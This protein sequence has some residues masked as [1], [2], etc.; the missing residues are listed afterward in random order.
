[1]K[2]FNP[3]TPQITYKTLTMRNILLFAALLIATA[4]TAQTKFMQ[5]LKMVSGDSMALNMTE[6]RYAVRLTDG[7]SKLFYG[8]PTFPYE[9]QSTFASI[10]AASCGNLVQF[11]QYIGGTTQIV[12]INPKY[13]AR[14]IAVPGV[15]RTN[16]FM[17]QTGELRVVQGT[18]QTVSGLLSTCNGGGGGGGDNWGTQFVRTDAT[19]SGQGTLAS[20]LKI[21]QQGATSGEVLKWNGTTWVPDT[22]DTGA[23]VDGDYGDI[24]VSGGATVW[25]IDNNTIT[26]AKIVNGTIVFADIQNIAT[27]KVL[28]RTTAGTGTVELLDPGAGIA[29]TGGQIVNTGDTNPGDDGTV[30]SVGLSAPTDVFNV[31]GSPV[32]TTGTLALTFDNQAPN[33]HFSGPASGGAAAPTFRALVVADIPALT[34]ANIS[35]FTEAS[36][37]ISGALITGGD[38]ITATYNDAGANLDIDWDGAVVTA[39]LTGTGLAGAGL[40]IAQQGATNNQVLKWNGTNWVPADDDSGTGSVTSV[41]L[42]A[43]TDV[44]NVT[45]SPVTSAGTLTLS[46]DNQTANTVFAGPASGGAATPAF[47]ALVLADLAGITIPNIYNSNGTLTAARTVTGGN[48]ALTYTGIGAHS[49]SGNGTNSTTVSGTANIT[50]STSGTGDISSTS[51][52]EIYL[53]ANNNIELFSTIGN[54]FID[55]NEGFAVTW[56]DSGNAVFTDNSTTINGLQ[57][58]ADYCATIKN[59]ALSIPSVACVKS[60]IT[61]SLATK[62]TLYSGDG[63]IA[64]NRTVSGNAKSLA[65]TNLTTHSETGS[66]NNTT[67]TTGTGDIIESSASDISMTASGNWSAVAGTDVTIQTTVGVINIESADVTSIISE[68]DISILSNAGGIG[69]EWGDGAGDNAVITDASSVTSGFQY[70]ADYIAGYIDR[71]LP[72]WG[73]VK[74]AISDSLAARPTLY[75][76]NGTLASNRTVTG[77][78]KSLTY[79]G[80]TSHSESGSGD[81][82]TTT[83]GTA[84]IVNTSGDDF[85]ITSGGGLAISWNGAG[86]DAV[87]TDGSTSTRGLEYAADYLAGYVDRTLPDW[88]NV[89]KVVGDSLPNGNHKQTLWF[90][91]SNKLEATNQ[92][93]TDNTTVAIG[94]STLASGYEVYIEGNLRANQKARFGN[95]IG[96]TNTAAT[97][98]TNDSTAATP[99]VVYFSN[100]SNTI[101]SHM[102]VY[103]HSRHSGADSRIHWLTS[104][105]EIM[106]NAGW[107]TGNN[108]F[109]F[110]MDPLSTLETDMVY[111]ILSTK[112]IGIGVV[113]PTALMHFKAQT[114]DANSAPIKLTA[115][116]PMPTSEDGSLEYVNT[117]VGNLTMTVGSD[118]YILMK[119]FTER[120]TLDYPAVGIAAQ[121]YF[122][123]TITGAQVGDRVVVGVPTVAQFDGVL[124]FGVVTAINT[125]RLGL[126]NHSGAG[127]N[128]AS[129][130]FLI[131]VIH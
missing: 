84:D 66:G 14:A 115:A 80:L 21:A 127:V 49:E 119:G 88:G 64:S 122:D 110:S 44:F 27:G 114:A 8:N 86:E 93:T 12:G 4:A 62:V 46:F 24:T 43:P 36:Q 128:P 94:R 112:E 67:T 47:R 123:V 17:H 2:F 75:S 90:N 125:V 89:K 11:T 41:G 6:V 83:T 7:R 113:T 32:T 63:T 99:S 76:G 20:L 70:A 95:A 54:V 131:T 117:D 52:G 35:D 23:L 26:S 124:Y 22:D 104:N 59:N 18:Y 9:T 69:I 29:F 38:Q 71:T 48:F 105:A 31:A 53:I 106:A 19:L 58:A 61:D 25:T 55:A 3:H 72:D 13:V 50:E 120:E 65:Y 28:G 60:L 92:I 73:N 130:E 102:D 15:A 5:K 10:V 74:D 42:A 16:L 37:D 39:R 56:D 33:T 126:F 103:I 30:T 116:A 97:L 109:K 77:N 129:G 34:S 107:D 121:G 1:M 78:A 111:T 100:K 91:A 96:V 57:Y 68:S 98:S 45:N 85:I 118:R 101:S 82:T 51:G 79:T 108:S 40:D 87:I 81:N